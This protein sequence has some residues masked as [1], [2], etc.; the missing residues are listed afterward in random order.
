MADKNSFERNFQYNLM[1]SGFN[2]L[3]IIIRNTFGK[4]LNGFAVR[5]S[6]YFFAAFI[7][8]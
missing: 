8:F 6:W 7:Y 1:I 3:H 2:H 4:K 5:L